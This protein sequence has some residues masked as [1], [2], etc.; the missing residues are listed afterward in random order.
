M[1]RSLFQLTWK[2]KV[3]QSPL[4]REAVVFGIDRPLPGLLI[5]RSDLSYHLSDDQVLDALWS[6]IDD[7]NTKV[8]AFGQIGREYIVI[9]PA[10]TECPS[11][12]K[13]S[14]KRAQVYRDKIV[15]STGL[16]LSAVELEAW[17]MEKFKTEMNI[18]LDDTKADF[19]AA[20]IDSQKAIQMRRLMVQSLD[21]GEE[22]LKLSSLVVFE[23]GN[24][25]RLASFLYALRTSSEVA[26]VNDIELAHELIEKYS[27]FERFVPGTT[28]TDHAS[29]VS[30]KPT[31][32]VL[33]LTDH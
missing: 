29:I 12:N 9:L 20:G 14:I 33:L 26:E 6:M 30:I 3:R 15:E 28:Q 21:L 24:V 16:K 17:L 8:S 22:T 1:E 23:Y 2:E 25:E 10:S 13:Q 18:Q 4:V 19:Y 32:R 7:A 31:D 27:T 5:F 11:T